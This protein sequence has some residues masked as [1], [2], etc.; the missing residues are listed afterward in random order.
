VRFAK[1]KVQRRV[2]KNPHYADRFRGAHAAKVAAAQ[3]RRAEL[4]A[5][6]AEEARKAQEKVA[7]SKE[8]ADNARIVRSLTIRST[9]RLTGRTRICNSSSCGNHAA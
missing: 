4:L 9:E 3:K 5:K 2:A 1:P 6:Q 8:T 7:A